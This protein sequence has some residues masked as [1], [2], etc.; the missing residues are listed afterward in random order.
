MSLQDIKVRL[1]DIEEKLPFKAK[2]RIETDLGIVKVDIGTVKQ[3]QP[4]FAVPLDLVLVSWMMIAIGALLLSIFI[5]RK[6]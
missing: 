1:E 6:S 5:R 2:A 4:T 3:A